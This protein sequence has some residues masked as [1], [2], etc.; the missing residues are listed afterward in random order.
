MQSYV[1][2]I[3]TTLLFTLKLKIFTKILQIIL[4]KIQYIKLWIGLMKYELEGKIITE[5]VGLRP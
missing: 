1:I 5:F 2:W 3:L 4:E